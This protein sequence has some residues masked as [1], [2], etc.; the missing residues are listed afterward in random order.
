[1]SEEDEVFPIDCWGGC[2]NASDHDQP[3][4]TAIDEPVVETFVAVVTAEFPVCWKRKNVPDGTG[5]Q[6]ARAE[7]GMP[8]EW[9]HWTHD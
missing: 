2:C 6:A 7:V 4:S 1:M 3:V 9:T 5:P 8:R